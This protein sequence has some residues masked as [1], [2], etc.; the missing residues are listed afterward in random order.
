MKEFTP[1]IIDGDRVIHARYPGGPYITIS[2]GRNNPSGDEVI[3]VWDDETD[4]PEIPFSTKGVV[5]AVRNWM[6]RMDE[7]YP[8]WY[9][10]YLENARYW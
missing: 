5:D 6:A 10:D 8:E 3:N 4:R 9:E 2:F 7:E 1:R